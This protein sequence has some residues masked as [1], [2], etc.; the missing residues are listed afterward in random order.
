QARLWAERIMTGPSQSDPERLDSLYE[1]AFS[2]A[3]TLEE[4]RACLAFLDRQM[5]AGH[6]RQG[7]DTQR[8][9]LAWTALCHVL[10]NMKEFIF[11]D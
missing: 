4:A 8:Q 7:Y 3:P 1:I 5:Q 2:R 10:F 11:I 6:A 9:T